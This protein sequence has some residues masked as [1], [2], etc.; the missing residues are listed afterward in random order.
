MFCHCFFSHLGQATAY[1]KKHP[2]PSA[3]SLQPVIILP[4]LGGSAMQAKLDNHTA[5]HWYA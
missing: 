2:K 4:G 3:A 1:L 5:P